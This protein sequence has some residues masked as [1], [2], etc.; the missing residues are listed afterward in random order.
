MPGYFFRV[1]YCQVAALGAEEAAVDA[2]PLSHFEL[3]V[4]AE[5]VVSVSCVSPK[6]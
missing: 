6:V 4:A 1:S 5:V 3:A 2:R